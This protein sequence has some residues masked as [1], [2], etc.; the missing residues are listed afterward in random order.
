MDQF[1]AWAKANL[2]GEPTER[3]RMVWEAASTATLLQCVAACDEEHLAE[4]PSNPEDAAYQRGVDDCVSA[5][6][7]IGAAAL[8]SADEQGR[9][10]FITALRRQLQAAIDRESA[11]DSAALEDVKREALHLA[12]T[13]RLVE[14]V[15]LYR[16]KT[17]LSL[18]EARDAVTNL[19]AESAKS[20]GGTLFIDP[21]GDP[22]REAQIAIVR[23]RKP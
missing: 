21:K 3:D 23:K 12:Q 5:L 2:Q 22:T 16:A 7:R 13:K 17:G 18:M 8:D 19:L 15:Q 14:A 10:R 20:G 11:I 1:D 4:P 9:Q 6:S